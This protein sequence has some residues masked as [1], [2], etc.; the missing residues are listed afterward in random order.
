MEIKRRGL[1][2][3]YFLTFITIGI[4]HLYWLVKTKEEINSMG[5]DIPTGWL[6]II[7]IANIWWIW[8]YSE[9]FS[10]FIKKD[11]NEILWFILWMIMPIIIPAIVQSELNKIAA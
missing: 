11:N 4:Y 3:I 6:L 8:R 7:P 2:M 1:F 10:K 5:A 9:C